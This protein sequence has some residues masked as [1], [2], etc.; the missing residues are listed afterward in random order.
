MVLD[1]LALV[2]GLV[3]FLVPLV[4]Y[5]YLKRC[6]RRP[7][8]VRVDSGYQPR[9]TVMVPTYNEASLIEDRLENLKGQDYLL[10]KLEMVVVDSGSTDGTAEVVRKWALKNPDVKVKV[11]EEPVRRG[12]NAALNFAL[13]H[14]SEDADVLV[15]TDADC[16]WGSDALGNAVKHLSDPRVGAVTCSILPAK[17]DEGSFESTYRGLNNLVR[18]AE[19][20]LWSTPIA[21][22]PFIA[23]KRDTL[24]RIGGVPMWTG[25]DD[26]APACLAAFA[27]YRCLAMQDVV[28]REYVP[29][30]LG[31]NMVRRVRRA[32]HLIQHFTK[33]GKEARKMYFNAGK[34]F[35]MILV[36]EEFLHLVNPWLLMLAVILLLSDFALSLTI[37]P[38]AAFLLFAFFGSMLVP[39][40]RT[41]VLTQLILVYASIKN[42]FKKELIWKPVERTDFG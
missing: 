40:F 2:F 1:V 7:W 5:G 8:N 20:K 37:K 14:V 17:D 39:S 18:V 9:V 28:V 38:H 42:L 30:S 31:E 6:L 35:K 3:H 11:L 13:K 25:A 34:D 33:T 22:G 19:S 15:F 41:G 27:G 4:Y 32:Q 16:E 23:F 10:E 36:I 12:M 21:H 24:E 29:R 26:S